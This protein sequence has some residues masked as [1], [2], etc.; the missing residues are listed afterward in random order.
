MAQEQRDEAEQLFRS[1]LEG[2]KVV[3]GPSGVYTIQ[4]ASNNLAGVW[5]N[6]GLLDESVELLRKT[7]EACKSLQGDEI[8]AAIVSTKFLALLLAGRGRLQEAEELLREMLEI[9]ARAHGYDNP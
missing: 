5:Q 2:F 8:I 3:H 7:V 4:C 6:R 1:S 9:C